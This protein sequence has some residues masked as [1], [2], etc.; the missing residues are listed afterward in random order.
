[1]TLKT[2]KALGILVFVLVYA[3][4]V[5][6]AVSFGYSAPSGL[7]LVCIPLFLVW[8]FLANEDKDKWH[9]K[10]LS[11][12]WSWLDG[13]LLSVVVVTPLNLLDLM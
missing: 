8:V 1:M 10:W 3:I 6:T 13:L 5:Q 2:S 9:S 7:L 12:K 4:S 11:L